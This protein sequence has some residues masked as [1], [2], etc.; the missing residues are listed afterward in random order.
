MERTMTK[1]TPSLFLCLISVMA[2]SMTACSEKTEAPSANKANS[3]DHVWKSQTDTLKSAKEMS[4]E[5]QESLKQQQENL[6]KNN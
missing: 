2:V 3:G 5:M 1:I 6:D 4:N